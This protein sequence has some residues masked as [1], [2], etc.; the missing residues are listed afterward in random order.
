MTTQNY[1]N[2]LQNVIMQ[3][4]LHANKHLVNE[5]ISDAFPVGR[6]RTRQLLYI[7][8]NIIFGVDA[9]IS[10]FLLIYTNITSFTSVVS[11]RSSHTQM[12]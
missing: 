12:Y 2:I 1:F 4:I 8:L 6:G 7:T 3:T 5:T 10:L 9:N 11:T